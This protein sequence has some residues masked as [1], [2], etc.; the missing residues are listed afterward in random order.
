MTGR[1]K[2]DDMTDVQ[3]AFWIGLTDQRV[4]NLWE[5]AD[6]IAELKPEAKDL[7]RNADKATLKWLERASEEDV[8]QLQYSIKFMEASKLLGKVAWIAA[9]AFFGALI[10]LL[11]LWEKLQALF[12][13]KV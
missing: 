4:A 10:T 2:P 1:Q 3:E 7:L 11:T 12:K 13:T 9:A 8:A 5:A 6:Y